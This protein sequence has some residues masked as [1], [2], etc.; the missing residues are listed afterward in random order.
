MLRPQKNLSGTPT[1]KIKLLPLLGI[2]CC[3][4]NA[5]SSVLLNGNFE[6]FDIGSGNYKSPISVSN[7]DGYLV[8]F[9]TVVRAYKETATNMG[10]LTT[11]SDNGIELWKSF[12]ST[13]G[14]NS[15]SGTGQYAELNYTE[16]AALYQD[17]TIGLTGL[18]DYGFAHAARNLGTDVMKVRITY[19]GANDIFGDV[20]DLVV[21][22]TDFSSTR[23]GD[24]STPNVWNDYAVDNAFTSVAGGTYRFSFGAVS[25]ASGVQSEGNFIDNVRFGIDVVPEPSSA[26]LGSLG[27]LALLRRRRH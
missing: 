16:N 11:A 22:D 18:V 4:A 26:L 17:V 14:G 5:A 12:A 25:T 15:S 21:V 2:L 10:W 24:R 8:D 7:P 9:G 20:D 6:A 3:D 27:A 13:S 23:P 19:L 1:Y